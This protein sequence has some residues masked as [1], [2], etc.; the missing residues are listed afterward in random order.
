MHIPTISSKFLTQMV[1]LTEIPPH[2][3]HTLTLNLVDCTSKAATYNSKVC[4]YNT[5][6]RLEL[7]HPAASMADSL[8][9]LQLQQHT[10]MPVH[11]E[12]TGLIVASLLA[13]TNEVSSLIQDHATTTSKLMQLQDSASSS[14]TSSTR[15]TSSPPQV[16]TEQETTPLTP[17]YMSR[18]SEGR[19]DSW[20]PRFTAINA[21]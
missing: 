21:R 20:K 12:N 9:Q 19:Y 2:Y 6:N 15:M 7:Q 16:K 11:N 5:F 13:P 10:E 4:K 3:M 17:P 18:A 1:A 8:L 14:Q